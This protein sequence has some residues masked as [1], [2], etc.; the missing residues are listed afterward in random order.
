MW[1][2]YLAS[3]KPVLSRNPS[4]PPT[5]LRKIGK[6]ASIGVILFRL[7]GDVNCHVFVVTRVGIP[8]GVY[9]TPRVTLELITNKLKYLTVTAIFK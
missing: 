9:F 3:V 5:G 7:R 2:F 8:Q 6:V 4:N 1:N